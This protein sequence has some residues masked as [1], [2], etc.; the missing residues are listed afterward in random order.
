MN[1]IN[2]SI[3]LFSSFVLTCSYFPICFAGGKVKVNELKGIRRGGG[4]YERSKG[5]EKSCKSGFM[6]KSK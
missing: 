6:I 1:L 2:K 3:H 4:G 5:W